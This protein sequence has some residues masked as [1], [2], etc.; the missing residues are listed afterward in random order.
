MLIKDKHGTIRF[1]FL[2]VLTVFS[3][4]RL[5]EHAASSKPTDAYFAKYLTS[6][7]LFELE[8]S[9]SNFRRYILIQFLIMFHYL[10]ASVR[11]KLESQV[12]IIIN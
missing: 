10:K 11:F 5:D 4:Y 6:K 1:L 7:K 12:S 9:D 8:L 3:S 2:Q